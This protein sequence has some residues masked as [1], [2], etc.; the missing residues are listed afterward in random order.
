MNPK[1]PM[2]PWERRAQERT[3]PYKVYAS[4]QTDTRCVVRE[5]ASD[6][7]RRTM[8]PTDREVK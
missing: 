8:P 3:L 1:R 6:V 2:S 4:L 7:L 5:S